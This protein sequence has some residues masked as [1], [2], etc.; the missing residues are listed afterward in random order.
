MATGEYMCACEGGGGLDTVKKEDTIRGRD[1]EDACAGA[2]E[3]KVFG[4]F[5]GDIGARGERRGIGASH[6]GSEIVRVAVGGCHWA[7]NARVESGDAS[8]KPQ[9]SIACSSSP[10]D[11]FERLSWNAE[12]YLDC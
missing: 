5:R 11:L 9:R 12:S 3:G 10:L 4:G 8:S 7:C 2:G 1:Q 6:D